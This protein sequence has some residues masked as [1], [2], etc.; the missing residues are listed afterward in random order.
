MGTG[1]LRTF[2]KRPE[3]LTNDFFANLLD[4]ST[5]WEA[6]SEGNVCEGCDGQS[7]EHEWAGSRASFEKAH[8]EATPT[9]SRLREIRRTGSVLGEGDFPRLPDH[10]CRGSAHGRLARP[11]G[12][13]AE[14]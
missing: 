8:S 11:A 7:D 13:R 2:A 14:A 6:T 5:T 9:R 3:T 1:S 10:V 12:A 4:M